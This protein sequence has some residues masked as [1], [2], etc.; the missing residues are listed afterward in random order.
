M[1]PYSASWPRTSAIWSA[2]TGRS[3]GRPVSR[4]GR[5]D[6]PGARAI[7]AQQVRLDQHEDRIALPE[8][9]LVPALVQLPERL[10]DPLGGGVGPEQRLDLDVLEPRPAERGGEESGDV[11]GVLEGI[12]DPRG[13]R[14]VTLELARPDRQHNKAR[15]RE[16]GLRGRPGAGRRL[17]RDHV[18]ARRP[19]LISI[20]PGEHADLVIPRVEVERHLSVDDRLGRVERRSPRPCRRRP[21]CAPLGSAPDRRR[22]PRSR[23][24]CGSPAALPARPEDRTPG[25]PGPRP[26]RS[27]AGSRRRPAPARSP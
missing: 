7:E 5:E 23:P 19:L 18:E 10:I 15:G 20:V 25:G 13:D 6:H 1:Q 27:A 16:H 17:P 11:A 4:V 3:R 12:W 8:I 24:G 22:P 14:V 9:A 2:G 26:R 21:G